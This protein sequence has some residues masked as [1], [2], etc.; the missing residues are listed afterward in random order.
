LKDEE[1]AESVET[2]ETTERILT[3]EELAGTYWLLCAKHREREKSMGQQVNHCL[4][5]NG[6]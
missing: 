4:R 1:A 5:E 6:P 2:V 3:E